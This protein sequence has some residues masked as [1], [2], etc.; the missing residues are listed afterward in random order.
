MEEI[1]IN[2]NTGMEG[3][4]NVKTDNLKGNLNSIIVDSTNQAEIV[5]ESSLGYLIFK[6]LINGVEYI[7][8]RV[9]II[10]SENNMRDILTFDKF[11]L[12]EEL[13]ITIF[14]QQNTEINLILRLD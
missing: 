3:Q 6:R 11:L 5:V 2:T 4:A 13:S 7:A 1:K 14:A 10:P 9:R 8:P 12:N